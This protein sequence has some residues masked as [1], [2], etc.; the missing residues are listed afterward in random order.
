VW[1]GTESGR[2]SRIDPATNRAT[3]VD[4]ADFDSIDMAVDGNDVWVADGSNGTVVRFDAASETVT[5]TID[6]LE[7]GDCETFR[8]EAVTPPDQPSSV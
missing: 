4:G 6:L 8:N 2:L 5:T 1:V 3:T 7:F